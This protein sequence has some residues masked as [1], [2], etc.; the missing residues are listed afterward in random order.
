MKIAKVLITV[1][2]VVT[3]VC[4]VIGILTHVTGTIT[5]S[6]GVFGR[7]KDVAEKI[8][9]IGENEMDKTQTS[10]MKRVSEAGKVLAEDADAEVTAVDAEL[11]LGD[12]F[13]MTGDKLDVR[14]E[15]DEEYEPVVGLEN[16]VLTIRQKDQK[17]LHLPRNVKAV[18][19][20]TIP[21]DAEISS[22]RAHLNLGDL[23]V[24]GMTADKADLYDDLGNIKIRQILAGTV[25][26]GNDLGDIHIDDGEADDLLVSCDKGDIDIRNCTFVNLEVQQDL[27]DVDVSAAQD[28]TEARLDLKTDLG[29]IKINGTSQGNKHSHDG[30]GDVR[31]V[32]HNDL[33]DI[34]LDY[35]K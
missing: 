8:A 29:D 28:L 21:E 3:A 32:I 35:I 4:M 19:T 24:T 6:G 31:V 23:D 26:V 12:M 9:E 22:L 16:G 14:Y 25:T 17:P 27:G 33:G 1:L 34:D 18:L 15:G 5:G 30:S 13:L 2:I 10:D 7:P 11:R 20:V